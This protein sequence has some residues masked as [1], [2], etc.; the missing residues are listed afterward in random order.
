MK[1]IAE[2]ERNKEEFLLP[3]KNKTK[4]NRCARGRGTQSQRPAISFFPIFS[5]VSVIL[6]CPCLSDK[7][8]LIYQDSTQLPPL[9]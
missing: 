2:L 9:L 3:E 4:Q 1:Y 7:H 6:K 8:L 5:R